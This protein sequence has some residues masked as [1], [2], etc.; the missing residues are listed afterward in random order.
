MSRINKFA[1][2]TPGNNLW[3][4]IYVQSDMP[5]GIKNK[6]TETELWDTTRF[7]IYALHLT[8]LSVCLPEVKS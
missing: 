5:T 7:E 4:C 6:E 1:N 2:G 8:W 3:S